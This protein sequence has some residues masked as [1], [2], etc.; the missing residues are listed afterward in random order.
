[1]QNPRFLL[2]KDVN[3]RHFD[4]FPGGGEGY[5]TTAF[6]LPLF[7]MNPPLAGIRHEKIHEFG[8]CY[9][10]SL[11]KTG[12]LLKE[13]NIVALDSDYVLLKP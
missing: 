7:G 12:W 5:S 8:N 9:T 11:I 2:H 3:V 1:M 4:E 6:I 13:F 10:L